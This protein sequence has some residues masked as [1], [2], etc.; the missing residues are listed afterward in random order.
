[1]ES[2]SFNYMQLEKNVENRTN[3]FLLLL[4]LFLAYVDILHAVDKVDKWNSV[5]VA[6]PGSYCVASCNR[7]I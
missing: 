2:C 7:Y 3:W 1:M 5:D 6:H 4:G